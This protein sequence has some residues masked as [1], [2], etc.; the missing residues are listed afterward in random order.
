MAE[1]DPVSASPS[2]LPFAAIQISSAIHVVGPS[3]QLLPLPFLS[4][5]F[6]QYVG[7]LF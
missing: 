6:T 4:S 7:I 3:R 1:E 5:Y 2:S